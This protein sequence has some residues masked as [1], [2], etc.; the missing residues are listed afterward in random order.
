MRILIDIKYYLIVSSM[1]FL[2][3]ISSNVMRNKISPLN[4]KNITKRL[5]SLILFIFL[6]NN[7]IY[8]QCT[9]NISPPITNINCGQSVNLTANGNGSTFVMNN[10]FNL[11]NAGPGWQTT[12]GAMFNNPCGPGPGG[13]H[14]WMGNVVP[15]PRNIRPV[16][17]DLSCGGDICFDFSQ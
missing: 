16:D 17:F 4:L 10:N 3:S 9:V 14:L 2:R 13:A 11:G 15:A 8:P 7:T 12:A 6:F 5:K 1:S